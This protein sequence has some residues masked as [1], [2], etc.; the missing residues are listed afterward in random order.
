MTTTDRQQRPSPAPLY[1]DAIES[2]RAWNHGRENENRKDD[3]RQRFQDRK[4]NAAARGLFSIRLHPNTGRNVVSAVP[5][6]NSST[7]WSFSRKSAVRDAMS[8]NEIQLR[9]DIRPFGPESSNWL[10]S[11]SK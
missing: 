3:E 7:K 8:S 2:E 5:V 11:F 1:T 9:T 10:A 4:V 6:L